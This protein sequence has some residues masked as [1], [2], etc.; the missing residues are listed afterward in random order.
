MGLGEPKLVTLENTGTTNL[1][2]IIVGL[3]GE[4]APYVQLA[5]QNEP[6]AWAGPGREIIALDGTLFV[7]EQVSFWSRAV[8]SLTD[9]DRELE[10]EYAFRV[11]SVGRGA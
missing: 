10:F 9:V 3:E 8:F 6:I 4:G 5:V 1:R 7:G 11:Q 2:R